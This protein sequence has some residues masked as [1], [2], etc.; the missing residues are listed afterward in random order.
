VSLVKNI[1]SIHGGEI[2]FISTKGN[3]MKVTV[4]LPIFKKQLIEK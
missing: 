1:V 4:W 3:G 2:D